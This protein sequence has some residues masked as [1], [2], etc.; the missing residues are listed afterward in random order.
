MFCSPA[1]L[2]RAFPSQCRV[3]LHLD[4]L[5]NTCQRAADGIATCSQQR[6]TVTIETQK[7]KI[8]PSADVKTDIRYLK[9][10]W[11][12]SKKLVTMRA[13]KDLECI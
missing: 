10:L 9:I 12:P 5:V 4:L 2:A 1:S 11:V 7:H 8:S 3:S 13:P 6:A